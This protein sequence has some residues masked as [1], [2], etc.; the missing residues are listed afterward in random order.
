MTDSVTFSIIIKFKHGFGVASDPTVLKVLTIM[1]HTRG[2]GNKG[3]I[4]PKNVNLQRFQNTELILTS[5]WLR[6]ELD[7]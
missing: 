6:T 7:R 1:R 3:L 2:I 5:G 4:S